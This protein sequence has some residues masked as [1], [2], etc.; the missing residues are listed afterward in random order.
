MILKKRLSKLSG[1]FGPGLLVAATGVGAGD[2]ATAAFTGI[3]V[4]TSI[5][6]VVFVGAGI[7]FILN[8]ELARYQIN[9][10]HTLLEGML[11]LLPASIKWVFLVYVVLWS[12][13]VAVALMSACG[14]VTYA[15][16]PTSFT[17]VQGKI[18]YGIIF[19]MIG[20]VLILRGGYRVFEK[21]M[22]I[23]VAAMF[24]A[25]LFTASQIPISYTSVLRGIITPSIPHEPQSLAWTLA[26]MGGVGGT[27]T[28]L[29]YGYWLKE[30]N[31]DNKAYL[32]RNTWDIGISYF[33]TAL[34]GVA[35]VIIGSQITVEGK[36]ASLIVQI[37]SSLDN[38]IAPAVKWVFLVG[39]WATV[40]TS[41]LGV[42][43]GVPYLFVDIWKS[44]GMHKN[45]TPILSQKLY[46]LYLGGMAII[47]ICGLWLGF[48][49]MQQLYSLIG[50]A[51]MPILT[52]TLLALYRWDHALKPLTVYHYGMIAILILI[53]TFFTWIGF[54]S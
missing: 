42:W 48:A 1:I 41:L 24:V 5:L 33:T 36:G 54:F 19:S 23:C 40:F 6:W 25:I 7:K 32:Q 29:N 9:T 37:S 45:P 21:I 44:I 49:S 46:K 13:M 22:Q 31:R 39:A 11:N 16:F 20:Y 12:F 28:V 34:F 50:A 15:I 35:M 52:I 27:V 4:G 3:H 10:G 26:L 30:T 17:P 51:F 47:P 8:D 43:Q 38:L 18:V 2:L 53:L 14:V